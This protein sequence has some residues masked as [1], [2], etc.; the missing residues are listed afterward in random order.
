MIT[1]AL[2]SMSMLAQ[3]DKAV[4]VPF[5]IGENAIIADAVVN[6]RKVSCMFDTGFSGS[7]VLSDNVSIGKPSGTMTLRDF[8]G[9]FAAS[10]VP[11]KTLMLGTQKINSEGMDAVQQPGSSYSLSYNTHAVGIMGME[12][13]QDFVLEINVQRKRFVLHPRSFDITKKVPDNKRTF[14]AKMLPKGVNSIEMAVEAPN[15]G[16]LTLALDTGNSFYATT[17][18]DVLE[19]LSLWDKTQKPKFM[20]SA[21]VA[22]GAVDSFNIALKDMKIFGVPTPQSVW[23]IIDLPSS[24]SDHDG[25]VGFGFLKNFNMIIDLKRRR[26]WL[27]NFTGKTAEPP[28]ASIGMSAWYYAEYQRYIVT[29]VTP[30]GPAEKAGI[31]PRDMLLAIDGDE[32][33]DVGFRGLAEKLEGPQGSKVKL[34]L[35]RAGVLRQMEVQ[36]EY[37][38]NG[39]LPV[40]P[41]ASSSSPTSTR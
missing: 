14:L 2:L 10:T 9:Q 12:V 5:V 40:A 39:D 27:E 1:C 31:K 38:I 36:R 8:V 13:M 22:S 35:S 19:K 29:G 32:A 33:L 17:H 34:T 26:V 21:F 28:T 18:R 41:A 11:I 4:E 6:G 25:T 16:K 37:L 3:V 30:Q 15:G 23:N 20:G 7:F 24:S